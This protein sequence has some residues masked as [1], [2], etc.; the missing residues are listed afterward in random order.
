MST[1]NSPHLKRTKWSCSPVL[2]LWCWRNVTVIWVCKLRVPLREPGL[3]SKP[4]Q[5]TTHGYSF[6][7]FTW[8]QVGFY[9]TT[10]FSNQGQPCSIRVGNVFLSEESSGVEFISAGFTRQDGG[11]QHGP[12]SDV[13]IVP[14]D[15]TCDLYTVP[16]SLAIPW[17][18]SLQH[19][20][21]LPCFRVDENTR[22]Q[23][24]NWSQHFCIPWDYRQTIKYS[25]LALH[26]CH[27]G[28]GFLSLRALELG[29]EL[30]ML[31][32]DLTMKKN[33]IRARKTRHV[34]VSAASS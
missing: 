5:L 12:A 3:A 20:M 34:S 32:Q 15:H 18:Q 14:H 30:A 25:T 19:Q 22:Q 33:K 28:L 2:V 23:H 11:Q 27:K 29:E 4:G 10:I 31:A 8:T 7:V 26:H 16:H 6:F 1:S 9:L 17:G 24:L 13:H 21:L